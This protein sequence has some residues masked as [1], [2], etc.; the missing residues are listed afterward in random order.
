M[1]VALAVL[2]GI[3]VGAYFM[4]QDRKVMDVIF[5]E[6]EIGAGAKNLIESA[7]DK[8]YSLFASL[9]EPLIDKGKEAASD[10]LDKAKT[11]ISDAVDKAKTEAL[12]SVKESVGQKLLS[13][14][15]NLGGRS[16]SASEPVA[17]N[18]PLGFSFKKGQAAI[19]IVK[20]PEDIKG[21]IFYVVL[22]GDGKKDEGTLAEGATKA[23]YHIWGKDGEYF[24]GMT[25]AGADKTKQYSW[26]VV[27]YP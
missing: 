19:L 9:T 13:V 6:S 18:L 22:W 11:E 16:L 24:V 12:Q 5:P 2:G 1:T 8:A 10:V 3:A 21:N 25:V 23:L 20:N 15:E 4:F 27:V 26:T 17:E 7:R 14:G